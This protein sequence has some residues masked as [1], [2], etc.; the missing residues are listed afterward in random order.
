MRDLDFVPNA[1]A[2][3]L[4][5][6]AT[7]TIG[8][9]VT[10]ISNPFFTLIAKGAG[11]VAQEAGYSLILCNSDEDSEK[12]SL[13]LEVLRRQRVEGLLLVSAGGDPEEIRAWN[14]RCGP[15]CL[16]DR[17]IPCLDI[18]ADGIDIVRS[19][20]VNAAERVVAHL[21]AH[22]HHRIAI[23][24]GPLYLSTA[25]ERLAGYQR[26][27]AAAGITADPALHL[28]GYYTV[29]SGYASGIALLRGDH[30]P[31]A[32]FATNNFLTIGVL[33][34]IRDHGLVVHNDVAVVGFDEIPQFTLVNPFL[35]VAAQAPEMIGRQAAALLLERSPRR[36]SHGT[37]LPGRE[38]VLATDVIIRSSCGCDGTTLPFGVSIATN[39]RRLH[40]LG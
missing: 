27:L 7:K 3:G 32:I 11:D 26:A 21:I 28:A 14:R 4:K 13:Y 29:D 39:E 34:A 24:N 25:A 40:A 35:T 16:I 33:A 38:H 22:G 31:T 9:V 12:Q 17:T 6:R 37:T 2:Q 23:V 36:A 8:L 15:V 19:D 5:A 10:D 18:V 30:P 1:L 20:S